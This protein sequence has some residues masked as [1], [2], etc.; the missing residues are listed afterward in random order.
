[1]NVFLIKQVTL[2]IV[3]RTTKFSCF[4]VN[5][6]LRGDTGSAQYDFHFRLNGALVR[7]SDADDARV[8][9]TRNDALAAGNRDLRRRS[10]NRRGKMDEYSV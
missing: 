1:M 4:S 8:G 6:Y 2:Y 7:L 3:Y 9:G 5:T 10:G